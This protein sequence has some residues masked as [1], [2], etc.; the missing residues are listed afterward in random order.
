MRRS[1]LLILACAVAL[2]EVAGARDTAPASLEPAIRAFLDADAGKADKAAQQVLATGASFD[3]VEARL[4]R[5]RD[6]VSKPTGRVPLPTTVNGVAMDNVLEVPPEYTPDHGWPLRV[7][8]HGGVGRPAPRDGGSPGRP[9]ADRIPAS[10]P[11]LVLHPRAY[12]EAEWW[13][14]A[15]VDNVMRL[16]DR[17]KR[18]YNVDESR[19][20]ITGVSDGGT[21]VYFF[22]MRAATPWAACMPLNGHPLVLANPDTGADG[23]FFSTNLANCPVQAVNG[24]QDPLYPAASV[25]PLIDMFTQGGIPITWHVYP[26]AKHDV[27]WWPQE[28]SKYEAFL[29][30]HPRASNPASI[31]WETDR[32]DR[33]NRFRWLVIGKL[34][35]R[36]SDTPLADV[37][38]F[39]SGGSRHPLYARDGLSGR[40]D[41]AR[42]GNTFEAKTRGVQEFTLLLS[43]EVVDFAQPV[44]VVVNG[45]PVF[46][47]T[48]KKDVATLLRWAARDD[49]RTMLYG[50]ELKLV[51]P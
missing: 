31:T 3:V 50:A 33:Y 25:Q 7:D 8:L 29:Q 34:G 6:F 44:K 5:G 11:Q 16:V 27:S 35:R 10:S 48:V 15:Q 49:D 21:G 1:V 17:V 24:G 51:V 4:K 37:N 42:H 45:K 43:P 22:A 18:A 19:T 9:L 30:A 39:E 12:A 28:R 32:T 46:D 40:V 13:T 41:V 36:S 26:D 20:Y 47:G 23:E 2:V 38:L 14:A